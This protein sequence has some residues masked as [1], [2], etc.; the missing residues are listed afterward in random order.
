MDPG[1]VLV[2][3]KKKPGWTSQGAQ[4]QWWVW[5]AL[6]SPVE[7]K[8]FSEE[9]EGQ[10]RE[11]KGRGETDLGSKRWEEQGRHSETQI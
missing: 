5:T 3:V 2:E 10:E 8:L 7:K 11:W 9:E 1:Q 4:Q 6:C